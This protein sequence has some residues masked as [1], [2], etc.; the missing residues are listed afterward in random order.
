MKKAITFKIILSQKM[1]IVQK[2]N[3]NLSNFYMNN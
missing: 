1:K 3:N 2:N